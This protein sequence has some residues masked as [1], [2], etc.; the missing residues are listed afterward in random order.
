[1][2]APEF[3]FDDL[4]WDD[5][6]SAY[7]DT[8]VRETLTRLA[9]E[10]NAED[11][12]YLFF[13][14]LLHQ[15]T[16]YPA[17]FLAVPHVIRLAETAQPAALPDIALFLGGVALHGR[18]PHTAGGVS[19]AEGEDW[20]A[21][22]TGKRAAEALT[23]ALPAIAALCEASYH[24]IQSTYYASGLAAALDHLQF[25]SW[26]TF[27]ENGGFVCPECGEDNEWLIFG[28]RLAV[29][30]GPYS[31]EDWRNGQP[32]HATSIAEKVPVAPEALE[33]MER[34]SPLDP[35]T[36]ALIDNYGAL[37]RCSFCD[38][39]GSLPVPHTIP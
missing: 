3:P 33:V 27:G 25:A 32:D 31:L 23:A 22:P 38:W 10:W 12:D 36:N 8:P 9:T 15:D 19:L 17:T 16:V 11:A 26:L 28:D 20:A 30:R 5:A 4:A 18:L 13:S 24:D 14:A 29:Y 39:Q 34:L 2:S 21:T 7:G 1:M 35:M 6:P 37:A